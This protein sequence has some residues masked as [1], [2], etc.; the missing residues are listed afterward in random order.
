MSF[1]TGQHVAHYE[2]LEVLGDS[3]IGFGYRVRNTLGDRVEHLR[4][5][6]K[7]EDPESVERFLREIKVHARLTHPHIVTFYNAAE[8]DGQLVMTT[9]LVEGETLEQR[10]ERGPIP[11]AEA[12]RWTGQLLSALQFA[13]EHGVIH[14]EVSPANILL[15]HSGT[16]KLSGFGLAKGVG[17]PQLTQVGTVMGWIEYMAPEQIQGAPLDGRT[18]VY[19]TGAVLYEMLTGQV[20]FICESQ[21]EL[22]LAH[23]QR[24]PR[25]PLELNPD[26]PAELSSIVLTALEKDPEKRFASALA[27]QTALENLAGSGASAKRATGEAAPAPEPDR[28]VTLPTP[29]PPPPPP[30]VFPE[31]VAR[32][33]QIRDVP[34]PRPVSPG[35]STPR[36]LLLALVTFVAVLVVFYWFLTLMKG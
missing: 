6:S 32:P 25:P 20:P 13:H 10:L 36:L 30:V 34:A 27:F 7:Q 9:E 1:E 35:W 3:R 21:F 29:P 31:P 11:L 18:D 16:V 19:S 22:M 24:Q 17:D 5:L 15:T 14:R 4:V 26:L 23:V 12:L 33:S 8:I 2:I 28:T